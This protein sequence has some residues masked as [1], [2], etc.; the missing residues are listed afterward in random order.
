[1]N[2]SVD[3]FEKR[4]D[5]LRRFGD[6]ARAHGDPFYERHCATA[7]RC[8]LFFPCVTS[9][10]CHALVERFCRRRRCQTTDS[11]IGV[12]LGHRP[13][14][15]PGL[16]SAQSAS[17][18]TADTNIDALRIRCNQRDRVL[19]VFSSHEPDRKADK[20]RVRAIETRNQPRHSRPTGDAAKLRAKRHQ[21]DGSPI[22]ERLAAIS[23]NS[24][25]Q[26]SVCQFITSGPVFF[27][28][29]INW[30]PVAQVDFRQRT[31]QRI[32][33]TT[34]IALI[35]V[36]NALKRVNGKVAR[37]LSYLRIHGSHKR[38]SALTLTLSRRERERSISSRRC[39]TSL[40]PSRS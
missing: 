39:H 36:H 32:Q 35:C 15:R 19:G 25:K 34:R 23:D 29:V 17:R 14:F 10:S 7:S 3:P 12:E 28:A 31:K 20:L 5:E 11:F 38:A 9:E 22:A 8:R 21:A 1:M 27:A 26:C 18:F 40:S 33:P 16:E 2:Q 13:Q 37:L 30:R 24:S 6:L 4:A